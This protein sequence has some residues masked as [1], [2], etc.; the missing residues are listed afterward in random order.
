MGGMSI[1]RRSEWM[2]AREAAK[3]LRVT[4]RM[5]GHYA[6]NGKLHTRRE[7]RRVWYLS[8]DVQK[9]AAELQ[10]D[11]RPTQITRQ[12]VNE[13]MVKYISDRRQI[14]QD[15]LDRL[16]RIE[17]K[18]N[19]PQPAPVLPPQPRGPSWQTITLALIVLAIVLVV[20]LAVLRFT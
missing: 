20:F 11:L 6:K 5:I 19:Q 18:V 14:D 8:E 10:T 1:E 3:L 7:G 4:E 16:Q 13:E 9:L 2:T 15:V 12:D 17:D